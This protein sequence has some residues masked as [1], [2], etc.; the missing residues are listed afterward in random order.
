[1]TLNNFWITINCQYGT[2]NMEH[3]IFIDVLM[4]SSHS[5]HCATVV[6]QSK[7]RTQESVRYFYF[8]GACP[9]HSDTSYDTSHMTLKILSYVQ[10]S[11]GENN[12]CIYL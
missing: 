9:V 5:T 11:I 12:C 1:M 10:S 7:G 3:R 6:N 2:S 8:G 4:D